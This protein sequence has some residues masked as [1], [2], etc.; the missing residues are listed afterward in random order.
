MRTKCACQVNGHFYNG[1]PISY[2]TFVKER[3][4]DRS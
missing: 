4:I 1:V 3:V 2:K